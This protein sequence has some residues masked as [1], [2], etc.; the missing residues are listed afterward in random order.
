MT[1]KQPPSLEHLTLRTIAMPANTNPSGN[2]F[3]GWLLYQMDL[4]ASNAATRRAKG[5]AVTVSI[6][7]VNFRAPVGVGDEV[8]CYAEVVKVGRTSLTVQVDVWTRSNRIGVAR[9]VAEG[10]FIFVAVDADK[11]PRLINPEV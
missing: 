7:S 2:I 6:Q 8:S 10:T 3:G 4:A 5:T 11:K 9:P 1:E